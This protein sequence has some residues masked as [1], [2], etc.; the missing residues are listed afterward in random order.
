MKYMYIIIWKPP[1]TWF[2]NSRFSSVF[3]TNFSLGKKKLIFF[4]KIHKEESLK[5]KSPYRMQ[6]M[7][8]SDVH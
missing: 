3:K 2:T 7:E 1:L 4:K 8:K 6:V 5:K